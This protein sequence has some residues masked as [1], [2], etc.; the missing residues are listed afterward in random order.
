MK[1]M[2]SIA[3]LT[4]PT[5]PAFS[6]PTKVVTGKEAIQ[7]I[8]SSLFDTTIEGTL[9]DNKTCVMSFSKKEDG[10][11]TVSV[12]SGV[13]AVELIAA[14]I[15]PLA[16]VSVSSRGDSGTT[17]TTYSFKQQGLPTAK[18]SFD[19]YEDISSFN[20]TVKTHG[21]TVTCSYQE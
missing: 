5:A 16:Q 17:T 10:S 12:S 14:T 4:L 6:A 2:I 7:D 19:T 1:K 15:S 11:L 18:L 9:P 8:T 21:K 3:L 20:L 13:I